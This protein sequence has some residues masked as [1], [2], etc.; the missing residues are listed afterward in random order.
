METTLFINR[1]KQLF[2]RFFWKNKTL[3]ATAK[4]YQLTF[5]FNV[6]DGIGGDI[7]YKYGVYAEDYITS[8]LLKEID[9]Q[10]KDLILDIGANIGWYS[11][12]LSYKARPTIYSFEPEPRNFSFLSQNVRINGRTNINPV[13]AAVDNKPGVM[14]LHLYKNHNQG[15]HSFIRHKKSIG[16]V[17]V[18]TIVVDEFLRGMVYF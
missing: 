13:N 2:F 3:T 17:D 18:K 15:R 8:F 7:Y 9:I 10:D 6:N 14:Q 16:T 1:L 4:K 12:V 11:L 5:R